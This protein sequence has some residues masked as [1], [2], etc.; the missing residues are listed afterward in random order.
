MKE[1]A[2]KDLVGL[3]AAAVVDKNGRSVRRGRMTNHAALQA[4]HRIAT[5]P[6][7]CDFDIRVVYPAQNYGTYITTSISVL[8][9]KALV[10]LAITFFDGLLLK[11]SK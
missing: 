10:V 1:E 6:R 2:E 11:K 5:I 8:S 3:V 7:F 4:L 9:V